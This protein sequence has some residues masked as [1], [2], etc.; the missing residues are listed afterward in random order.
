[1]KYSLTDELALINRALLRPG[2]FFETVQMPGGYFQAL[3][4]MGLVV[5]MATILIFLATLVNLGALEKQA[6]AMQN[7][8]LAQGPVPQSP[9][10]QMF[11]PVFWLLFTHIIG[12]MQHITMRVFGEKESSLAATQAVALYAV[13]PLAVLTALTGIIGAFF[14]VMPGP[15]M[16]PQ[17]Y[18]FYLF[19]GLIVFAVGAGWDGVI[20]VLGFRRWYGQNTGRALVAW[21]SPL[22]LCGFFCVGWIFLMAFVNVLGLWAGPT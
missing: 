12:L 15:D 8:G 11:F 3:K 13:I 5:L 6:L 22:V 9:W 19:L 21:F 14:P 10:N 1:M 20:S 7:Y 4:S 17:S 2:K 16:N 18:G